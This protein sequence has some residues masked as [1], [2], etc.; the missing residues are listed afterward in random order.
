MR[1]HCFINPD[2]RAILA[3]S[4]LREEA[5]EPEFDWYA[6]EPCL[7][8]YLEPLKASVSQKGI[9][10]FIVNQ[11]LLSKLMLTS[12]SSPLLKS[13]AKLLHAGQLEYSAAAV[14]IIL[15]TYGALELQSGDSHGVF[16]GD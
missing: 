10:I 15:R 2:Q 7:A 4:G 13:R 5:I 1:L 9:K 12:K 3:A 16:E 14:P 6:I 11:V 8:L